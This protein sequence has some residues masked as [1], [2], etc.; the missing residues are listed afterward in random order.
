MIDN[1]CVQC[2]G[3]YYFNSN[4]RLCT[5]LD[6]LCRN[7][8]MTNGDCTSCYPGYFLSAARCVAAQSIQI[9]NCNVVGANGLC[10]ECME[11]TYL[12]ANS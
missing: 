7:S 6:P 5:Q 3:G 9:A 4:Q 11:G 8:D 1:T 2:S 10:T 12:A